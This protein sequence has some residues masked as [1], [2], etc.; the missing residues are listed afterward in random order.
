MRLMARRYIAIIL[1]VFG[2]VLTGCTPE[3]TRTRGEDR[4]ADPGNWGRPVRMHGQDDAVQQI[5]Y[6][7]PQVGK[8]IE[9]S[10]GFT[11]VSP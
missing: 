1:L 6:E 2:I 5:Y 11:P 8:G 10:G 4:G 7:T 3:G 9:S